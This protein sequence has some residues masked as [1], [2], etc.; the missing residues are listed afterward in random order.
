M[1]KL[2]ANM[3]NESLA[4]IGVVEHRRTGYGPRA[5]PGSVV[6]LSAPGGEFAVRVVPE[7][8]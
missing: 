4:L 8:G 5:G 6:I 3:R 2:S 1:V 7:A